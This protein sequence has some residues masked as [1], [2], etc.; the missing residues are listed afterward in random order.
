VV[1]DEIT[2]RIPASPEAIRIVK[3]GM[4]AAVNEPL[5]TGIWAYLPD[6]VI[7]G[8]TGTA[9]NPHGEN[10]AWFV[11]FAPADNPKVMV[12]LLVEQGGSG[13]NWAYLPRNFIWY[14]FNVYEPRIS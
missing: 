2:G 4:V 11:C 8:K 14:Y 1:K 3:E 7:A 6:I 10:H 9:Q 13:G 12:L 5:G